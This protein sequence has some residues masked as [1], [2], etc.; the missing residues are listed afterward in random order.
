MIPPAAAALPPSCRSNQAQALGALLCSALLCSR[1]AHTARECSMVSAHA[2]PL[3]DSSPCVFPPC[4]L[5]SPPAP[6]QA[7]PQAAGPPPQQQQRPPPPGG[8]PPPMRPPYGMPPPGM[9]PPR[10]R[11]LHLRRHGRAEAV[12]WTVY[13]LPAHY[14]AFSLLPYGLLQGMAPPFHGGRPFGVGPP[15]PGYMPPPHPGAFRGMPPPGMPPPGYQRPPPPFGMPG[16]PRPPP[17]FQLG[18]APPQQSHSRPPPQ[19][20]GDTER[21]KRAA[22]AW[23]AHKAG[24][25]GIYYYNSLTEESSWQRPPGFTGDEAKASSNPVPVSSGECGSVEG[26]HLAC[27]LRWPVLSCVPGAGC[28]RAAPCLS[29]GRLMLCLGAAAAVWRCCRRRT[30]GWHRVAGGGV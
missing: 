16:M 5:C 11:G 24:D 19:R 20:G 29:P 18:A 26:P 23:S 30:C 25:G 9:L 27:S 28:C 3:P 2:R 1:R 14:A 13:A 8:P 15:P 17:A 6:S 12:L 22:D 10:V 21:G 4:R 7:V